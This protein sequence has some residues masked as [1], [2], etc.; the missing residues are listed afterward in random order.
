MLLGILECDM[1][2][3]DQRMISTLFGY[4]RRNQFEIQRP[5]K[6]AR[7]E[8]FQGIADYLVISP[9][10]FPEP[11]NRKKRRLELLPPAPSEPMK[12]LA[13]LSKQELKAQ[14]KRDRHLLNLLKLRIHPIMDQIKIKFKK[15]RTGIIDESH[16]RYLYD[17]EDPSLVSTDLPRGERDRDHFRP[18]EISKDDH[19]EPGLIE[20]S[21]GKFF[22]N[23][24]IVV[25]EKRLSNGY[26]KRPK[27][28]LS[29]IKKLTKD[30]KAIGDLARLLK[31]NELQ[32]NIEVDMGV[33]ETE[34]PSLAADLE[35]VYLREMRREKEL[36]EKQKQLM[37][38][39]EERRLQLMPPDSHQ[40]G[41]GVVTEQSTGPVM[42][43]EP[44]TNGISHHPRTP[45]NPP[46]PSQSSSSLQQSSIPISDLSDL[47]PRYSQSNGTSVPSREDLQMSN[48]QDGPSTS[49]DNPTQD[50]SFGQSAQTR[51][52]A[53]YTGAPNS[54]VQRRSLPGQFSQTSAVT[55]M[56]EGS[57]PQ[58]YANYASTTSSDKRNTGSSGDKINTQSDRFT[59]S[60]KM[61]TQ[62][63]QESNG[64][65]VEGGPD[66]SKLLE[67]S[68]S[69]SQLPETQEQKGKYRWSNVSKRQCILKRTSSI[70]ILEP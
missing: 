32:A 27:D 34:S 41:L 33:I 40:D 56:A 16:L 14:K 36:L 30:A 54:L 47:Q 5:P 60:D 42:L 18:Y 52:F 55:A 44:V 20:V 11:L 39:D 24:D 22:Y 9:A 28:F 17:E 66:L 1:D 35:Q 69:A 13:I 67:A 70:P 21:T 43:G 57:T 48:S 10:D 58:D 45:S 38:A 29:D 49:P 61:N 7:R 3:V 6:P 25:I 64:R 15:F 51:P 12:P 53:S 63:T 23:M 46:H 59:Q 37:G 50:S 4:S 31:A 65:Q 62:N 8:Y 26:Y 68:I 19:G 2:H